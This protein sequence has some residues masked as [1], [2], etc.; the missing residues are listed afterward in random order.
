MILGFLIVGVLLVSGVLGSGTQTYLAL[1]AQA[2]LAAVAIVGLFYR[3]AVPSWK[4][5]VPFALAFAYL[6]LRAGLTPVA[7]VARPDYFL[8][9]GGFIAFLLGAIRGQRSVFRSS[10][11]VALG[12]LL[13]INTGVGLYHLRDPAF[14]VLP[15][16]SRDFPG[17]RIGGLYTNPN[18]LCSFISLVLPLMIGSFMVYRHS[19]VRALLLGTVIVGVWRSRS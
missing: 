17:D 8:I 3:G 1:P 5:T 16:Y 9:L 4:V 13:V 2:L 12:M 15:G 6:W 14:S 19:L 18:H 7:Y 10:V 11:V